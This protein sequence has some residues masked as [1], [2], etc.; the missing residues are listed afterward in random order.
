VPE[1]EKVV[2]RSVDGL[3]LRVD[4]VTVGSML[5]SNR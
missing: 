1:G 2:V 4:P 3:M 5:S